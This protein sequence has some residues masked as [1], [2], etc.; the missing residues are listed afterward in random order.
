M[1]ADFGFR[2][3]CPRSVDGIILAEDDD[4]YD[5]RSYYKEK[6]SSK[7][8]N[9][10]NNDL[11]D[12]SSEVLISKT[13]GKRKN[14]PKVVPMQHKRNKKQKGRPP[15]VQFY[16]EVLDWTVSRI[17]NGTRQSLGLPKLCPG[18][19]FHKKSSYFSYMATIPIEEVR[20]SLL[21]GIKS[22]NHSDSFPVEMKSCETFAGKLS[23]I[24]LETDLSAM[25]DLKPG[26]VAIIYPNIAKNKAVDAMV[27]KGFLCTLYQGFISPSTASNNILHIWVSS[28]IKMD[29]LMEQIEW[30]VVP[31]AS[32]ISYQRMYV[33]CLEWSQSR[34]IDRLIGLKNPFHVKFDDD[35]I[36]Y[37]RSGD[38]DDDLERK[39]NDLSPISRD[40]LN[41]SQKQALLNCLDKDRSM[42]LIQGPPGKHDIDNVMP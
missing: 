40:G 23:L 28:S 10:D 41:D 37:P 12:Y 2:E 24:S 21:E 30:K 35:G 36:E 15:V 26:I 19:N 38:N 6:Y 7:S 1:E 20:V 11:E 17:L 33:A 14:S 9:I 16:E 18:S 32:V 5:P 22:I 27:E 13:A 4:D 34:F 3:L 29:I 42:E 39:L 31:I 25:Y 8:E